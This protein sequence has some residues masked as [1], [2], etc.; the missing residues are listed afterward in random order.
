MKGD[1]SLRVTTDCRL[2]Y[3]CLPDCTAPSGLCPEGAGPCPA[4]C[5]ARPLLK[6]WHPA[7]PGG[8]GGLALSWIA[9][10]PTRKAVRQAQRVRP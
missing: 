10:T 6:K 8:T 7:C 3:V 4:A 2:T 9:S 1:S 5:G